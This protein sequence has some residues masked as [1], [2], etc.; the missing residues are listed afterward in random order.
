M[1]M[2]AAL[3]TRLTGNAPIA[4]IVNDR[5]DWF[6]RP[7]TLPALTLTKVSPGRE[8]TMDGPDGLDE[9]RIQIDAWATRKDTVGALAAA[10]LA[11][12]EQERVAGDWR[13]HPASV[14]F[15]RW[16]VE[17]VAGVGPVF[18]IQ[19]DFAFYHQPQEG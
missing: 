11:E 10:V 13:F 14:E 9:P 2:E 5:V 3:L 12:M 18:R 19:Q 16:S 15:E 7:T 8:W 6:D 17:D 1:S 4:A